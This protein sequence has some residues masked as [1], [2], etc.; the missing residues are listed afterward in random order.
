MEVQT[1]EHEISEDRL[2]H[3][4]MNGWEMKGRKE[5]WMMGVLNESRTNT[6]VAEWMDG[7]ME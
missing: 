2:T 1:H 6:R 4:Q 7:W 3:W 5:E